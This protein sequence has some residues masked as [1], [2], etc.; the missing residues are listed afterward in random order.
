MAKT[1]VLF[2][3]TDCNPKWHSLPALIY[4]YYLALREQ[5][6][7][8][9]VTH[10]RN[11]ENIEAVLPPGAK[12]VYIDTEAT[13][14]LMYRLTQF[15]TRDPDKAM[16]FQ[17]ALNTPSNIYFEYRVWKHFKAALMSGEF[18]VV[19]RA[20]PMSPT[21]PSFLAKRSPVPFVIGPVLGGLSWPEAFKGEMRREGEWMN[22]VRK[23]HRLVPYYLSTYRNAAAILAGYKHTVN[24]IPGENHQRIIEFSEGGIHL[25]DYPEKVFV[26][27]QRSMILFVGRMVPFK[28]P[29]V[30]I[31]CFEK[32]KSLQNHRLVLV[33]D[34]P[35]LPRLRALVTQLELDEV[36]ELTG[37]LPF[38]R[39]RELM[40]EADVF[41][42][43]SIREQGGGVLTMASMSCT[44]CIV[45]DY[46]GPATRVPEGC[47][48]KV[49]LGSVDDII[50]SFTL[51]MESLVN[52]PLRI[53]TLGMAA[54]QF[55]AQFYGW[56]RKASKT[57]EI[58]NWVLGRI[59]A[60]PDFWQTEPIAEAAIK[61]APVGGQPYHPS[62]AAQKTAG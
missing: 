31:R 39:V 53:K 2:V 24:D 55:T 50:T 8:T 60:K 32:S 42:F 33:G 17:V 47:G 43:P 10:T 44:P 23:L 13:A 28:Q 15:L 58:Y 48:L 61:P 9:L 62:I 40:Y 21:V 3:A 18:D 36:I 26:D 51:A 29:E 49:P 20:S 19:H 4:E 38:E 12:V 52:D 35:E 46:G 1:R 25:E 41:A 59:P 57:N 16:T 34:G 30:L 37:S 54:R 14:S 6:D 27:K 5:V 11:K 45:V 22:Y 56:S 7:V